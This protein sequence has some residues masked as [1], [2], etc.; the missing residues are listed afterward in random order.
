MQDTFL[1]SRAN[2]AKRARDVHLTRYISRIREIGEKRR[3][4]R[5]IGRWLGQRATIESL[6]Y[7][8]ELIDAIDFL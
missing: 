3:R 7:T 1:L 2:S 5:K 4:A 8:M 6:V